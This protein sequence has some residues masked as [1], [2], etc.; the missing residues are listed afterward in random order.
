MKGYKLWRYRCYYLDGTII[1][2]EILARPAIAYAMRV[3]LGRALAFV[4]GKRLLV[5]RVEIL[6]Q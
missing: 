3:A 2:E 4:E 1:E 5:E 6:P